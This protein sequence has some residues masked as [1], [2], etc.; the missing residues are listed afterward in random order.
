MARE[1]IEREIKVETLRRI[2]V[3][4][5]EESFP[6]RKDRLIS[7]AGS[8][9]GTEKRKVLE[10]LQQLVIE[11]SIMIDNNDVWM[12]KRWLKIQAARDKDYLKMDDILKGYHQKQ[13]VL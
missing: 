10:Y 6:A 8:E 11:E 2:V 9:W 3:E 7:F 13:I 5:D 12:F 4:C 1:H